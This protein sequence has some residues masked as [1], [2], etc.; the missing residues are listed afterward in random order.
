MVRAVGPVSQW[1]AGRVCPARLRSA[2]ARGQVTGAGPAPG[3]GL[4]ARVSSASHLRQ[5]SIIAELYC[6]FKL[7]DT[8]GLS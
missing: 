3:G 5:A 4:P 6:A 2:G 7:K 1:H 8:I